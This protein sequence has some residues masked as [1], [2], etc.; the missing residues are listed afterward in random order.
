MSI[1]V[2]V[3]KASIGDLQMPAESEY[4]ASIL[5]LMNAVADGFNGI[6]KGDDHP[7]RT[8]YSENSYHD[9]FFYSYGTN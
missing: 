5:H 9:E 3:F 2:G 8:P 4:T 7:Q 6:T 1:S